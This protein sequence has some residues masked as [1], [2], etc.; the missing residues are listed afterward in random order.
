MSVLVTGGAGFIGSHVVERLRGA[1][2]RVIVLDNFAEDYDP[3]RK[4]R[5]V[6]PWQADRE[7]I[8]RQ[9]SYGDAELVR[10]LLTEFEI[11]QVIHLG[12][13]PGVRESVAQPGRYFENNVNHTLTLLEEIRRQP[14]ARFLYASSSTVYGRGAPAPF[15]EDGPLG[16]PLSPYGASKRAAEI[17]CQT[18]HQLHGVPVVILRLFNVYGP[19]LRPE[20]ALSIFTRAIVRGEKLPLFGDGSV[21]RDFANVRDVVAGITSALQAEQVAGEIINLGNHQPVS[22]QRVIE[23]I[24]QAVGK[25]GQIERFPARPEEMPLTYA[26]ISK[27]QR[28]LQFQPR[29]SIEEGIAEFVAWWQQEYRV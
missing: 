1:H 19:R 3:Q 7:V 11:R 2:R 17:L 5:N 14:V 24:E 22:V 6:A 16:V 15:V 25:K 28:L 21:L 29:V 13:S 26:D 12:G 10:Q 23:L 20:L 9:G 4:S 27:A 8:V 18:Y